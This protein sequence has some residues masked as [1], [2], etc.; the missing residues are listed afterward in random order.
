[1]VQL[2]TSQPLLLPT[3]RTDH[4]QR[5]HTIPEHAPGSKI[6]R[7]AA[8]QTEVSEIPE[9][10]SL[11]LKIG[12]VT[13]DLAHVTFELQTTE[14]RIRHEMQAEL[15]ARMRLQGQKCA[16]KIA[17]MRQRAE[18]HMASVRA[19]SKIRL[20]SQLGHRER[21]LGDELDEQASRGQALAA[22]NESAHE[23]NRALH[24][25]AMR[26]AR[27]NVALHKLLKEEKDKTVRALKSAGVRPPEPLHDPR[28][29]VGLQMELQQRDATIA[30]LQAEVERLLRTFGQ[31]E[32]FDIASKSVL[33]NIQA[34]ESAKHA[35][36]HP[37]AA[38]AS[39]ESAP[40]MQGQG[41]ATTPKQA[42]PGKPKS[43][44][45]APNLEA[46]SWDTNQ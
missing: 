5:K 45:T 11:Q 31:I 28:A 39:A 36:A 37:P 1:M 19:S 20:R 10:R 35:P 21:M 18:S 43:P 13:K 34:Y 17:F 23:E 26:Y 29:I 16:E 41:G 44:K 46:P 4:V 42:R 24:K 12:Q 9:L 30:V 2:S 14:R 15:E 40:V 6:R 25:L 33:D 38:L 32:P 27:E 7:H 22:L 3:I 8:S